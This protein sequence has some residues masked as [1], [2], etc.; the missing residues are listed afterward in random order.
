[1]LMSGP[2]LMMLLRNLRLFVGCR[3]GFAAVSARDLK[4]RFA[5]SRSGSPK[6]GEIPRHP[7][8]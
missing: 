8:S 6:L 5:S 7:R 2:S 3:I 1:M 4:L